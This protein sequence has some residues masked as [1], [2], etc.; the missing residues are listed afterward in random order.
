MKPRLALLGCFL[1]FASLGMN[2]APPPSEVADQPTQ[3]QYSMQVYSL[4][5]VASEIQHGRAK[6]LAGSIQGDLPGHLKRM[7]DFR[8]TPLKKAVFLA[9]ARLFKA[10]AM[11]VPSDL[12]S[13]MAAGLAGGGQAVSAGCF[14]LLSICST[15][16][17]IPLPISLRPVDVNAPDPMGWHYL[18]GSHCGVK[19]WKGWK[20]W[21]GCGEP[22]GVTACTGDV[23]AETGIM[24]DAKTSA[25]AAHAHHAIAADVPD[26]TTQEQYGMQVLDLIHVASEI[27]AGSQEQLATTIRSE[28][29][30][31]LR[32]MAPFHETP[33][34]KMTFQMARDL[35]RATKT[36]IPSDLQPLMS[37]IVGNGVNMMESAGCFKVLDVCGGLKCLPL[38]FSLRPVDVN[39]PDPMGFHYLIGSHCGF[40]GW[41]GWKF[42]QGC[43]EPITSS[44][45]TGDSTDSGAMQPGSETMTVP[46]NQR[47][48]E[49]AIYATAAVQADDTIEVQQ[50]GYAVIATADVT[51]VKRVNPGEHLSGKT[52]SSILFDDGTAL[53]LERRKHG[54]P[55]FNATVGK[56]SLLTGDRPL[57]VNGG[58]AT[59]CVTSDRPFTT[60][61]LAVNGENKT[62][63]VTQAVLLNRKGEKVGQLST[64][65]GLPAQS[66]SVSVRTLDSSGAVTNEGR[67][68]GGMLNGTPQVSF[69][70]PSYRAGDKGVLRIGNQQNYS[71]MVGMTR[72]GGAENLS[73][74][75]IRLV[76]FSDVKGLPMETPFS[77][78]T[79]PFEA[80][81]AGE[82]R[83]GV[84]FPRA[85]PPKPAPNP[86]NDAGMR[87]SNQVFERWRSNFAH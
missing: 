86:G 35:F 70:K 13:T 87:Q 20:F 6:R 42:W 19:G 37:D 52:I 68:G 66:S 7:A 62:P 33:V 82:A 69:D 46:Q 64:Y 41:K 38:P 72:F 24:P 18:L 59:V 83:V 27:H 49:G 53:L 65:R 28:L 76:Q 8:P 3:D 34:K 51:S 11:S 56:D 25:A 60:P 79:L 1:L 4:V 43:G 77:T 73:N 14:K 12:R 40:K 55:P 78:T 84:L 5:N 36:E 81:H 30:S 71:R 75:P 15:K 9:A 47:L 50:P 48:P 32:R 23:E 2:Q 21:Q 54:D 45:C 58:S 29:P 67:I 63:Q 61:A 10:S 74:E 16:N 22:V 85:V 80:V 44:A 17:C 26:Q 31:H 57:P 39:T